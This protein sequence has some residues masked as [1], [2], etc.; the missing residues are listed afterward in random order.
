MSTG[1]DEKEGNE[2]EEGCSK[3]IAD[4]SIEKGSSKIPQIKTVVKS[5]RREL[6]ESIT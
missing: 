5:G 1:P 2:V 3:T 4:S 6:P